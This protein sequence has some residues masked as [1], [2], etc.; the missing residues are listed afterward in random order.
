MGVIDT[1]S[2]CLAF[3]IGVSKGLEHLHLASEHMACQS[4]GIKCF[5][6]YCMLFGTESNTFERS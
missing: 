2:Q 6:Q 5:M 4:E 3:K 1:I